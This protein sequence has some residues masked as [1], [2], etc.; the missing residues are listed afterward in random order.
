MLIALEGPPAVGKTTLAESLTNTLSYARVAEVNELFPDRPNPEPKFWYCE[1]QLDRCRRASLYADCVL[2]GDPLQAIWFSWIYPELGFISWQES[3]EFFVARHRELL[4]PQC[5]VFLETDAA[6]LRERFLA[7]ATHRG[8][9]AAEA[10]R[11]WSRYEDMLQPQ[12]A[13]FE[14]MSIEYPGLVKF[15][16]TSRVRPG[17]ASISFASDLPQPGRVEFLRW[18]A[19]W[20]SAHNAMQFR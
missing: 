5:Y 7:R 2:D 14:A 10:E 9:T 15:L 17:P 13:F 11:K 12:R 20:L 3:L 18:L 1:R 4:L 19:S 6:A 16:D 8:T